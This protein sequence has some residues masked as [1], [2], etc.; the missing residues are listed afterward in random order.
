ME[1]TS[2]PVDVLCLICDCLTQGDLK[3]VRLIN[4][5]LSR[6]VNLR[7][8]RVFLSPNRTNLNAFYGIVASEKFCS[9]VREIVWD[10]ARLKFFDRRRRLL[11]D[12][13]MLRED[14]RLGCADVAPQESETIE[15]FSYCCF[16]DEGS[17]Y[18]KA[19]ALCL[20]DCFNIYNS[21]YDEQQAIIESGEDIEALMVGLTSFP[22]LERVTISSEAWRLQMSCPRFSTP[23]FRSL[24]TEFRMPT[25]WPWLG[26]DYDE[27]TEDER[28]KLTLPWDDA[29]EQWRGYQIVISALVS[30]ASNHNVRELII[31]TNF[32][33]TGIS[34]QLFASDDKN[35]GL[36]TTVQLFE[37][38]PLT[39]LELCL[40]V[41]AAEETEFACFHNGLLKKALSHLSA[42]RHLLLGT[43]I[44]EDVMQDIMGDN[45]TE[46]PWIHLDEILPLDFFETKLESL[47]LRN[48]FLRG[49]SLFRA[50]KQLKV[51]TAMHIGS[52][53][54]SEEF[55]WREFWFQVKDELSSTWRPGQPAFIM[56]CSLSS[57]H[58]QLD[59]SEQLAAFLYGD[60]ECPFKENL[61]MHA[62]EGWVVNN[63]DPDERLYWGPLATS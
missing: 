37:I 35:M 5:A 49:E 53:T 34:H 3:K 14:I 46:S 32:E 45:N 51:L 28:E 17:W 42:L 54:L 10:D 55:T 36:A 23:F 12:S 19:T 52:A 48:F 57:H 47:Q 58:T 8:T 59:I 41:T 7:F 16:F 50:F 44:H 27:L 11:H 9:Q 39:R 31:D 61:P 15:H 38:V 62:T 33:L 40:N 18:D 56:R 24:P 60:G 21:L 43:S 30:T 2:L 29:Y 4:R 13:A 26:Y 1:L 20:E 63:W 6:L 22:N 25:P